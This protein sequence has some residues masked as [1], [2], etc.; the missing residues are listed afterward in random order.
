MRDRRTTP[1]FLADG[2]EMGALMRAHDWSASTLGP[3]EG[4]PQPLRTVVRLLLNTRH[5]T[6]IFWGA[7]GACLY[8]D[9]YRQS[10]GFERHPSSL[11]RPA[12][13]VWN[14]IWDIIGPQIDYVMAGQGATWHEDQL[15]P[16]TRNGE[17]EDVY[18]TYSYG[19]IDDETAANGVGG[20]LVL[21]TETTT[22]VQAKQRLAAEVARQRQVFERAP[23]FIAVLHGPEHR[24]EFV[25]QAY[26][27]LFGGRNFIARTVREAFPELEGQGLLEVLDQVYATGERFVA[28]E[29][30]IRLRSTPAS[31]PTERFFDF[32]Y[33]PM[34]DEAGCIT[35]IFVEGYDVSERMTAEAALRE[36]NEQL[37]QRVEERT[38]ERDRLWQNSQDILAVIDIQGRFHAVS[39]VVTKVLGWTPDELV[40]RSALD[41]VHPEHRPSTELALA[42]AAHSELPAHDNLYRHK[43]GSYRWISWVSAPGGELIYATGRHVTGEKEAAIALERSQARLRTVFETSYQMQGLLAL[44]GTVLDANATSLAVIDSTLADVVGRAFWETPWFT[45]TPGMPEKVRAAVLAAADGEN[46]REEISVNVAVGLRSYDFSVRPI[47]DRH[48]TVIAIVPEAADTTEHRQAEEALR[49]SQK[50]E[51]VG[52]LTGG[53]A[54]DFN[55]LLT[56][57]TGSLE[58]L[59]VRMAQGRV[60]EFNRYITAAQGASK[61]AAALTHR[62][63]AFSRRQP[64]DPKAVDVNQLVGGMEELVRRTVGP[65][66]R[67]EVTGAAGLWT[68][69]ADPNQLES[70][71]LNLCINARDAMPDGGRLM[72]ETDNCRLDDNAGRR[73]ELPPGQYVALSVSDTGT[74]MTPDV[75]A[76]AFDPFFTTKPIG[77]GTGLGLSMIYG[78]ARQSGG[79][80][81]ISS[82]PGRG[83]TVRLYLPRHVGHADADDAPAKLAAAPRA[84]RGQ[85]VLVVDDEPTVRML[86]SEVLEDLGYIVVEAADGEAGLRVLHSDAR[87][88]LL[89]TDLGLPGGTNGRQVADAGRML[90]PGL[91]VLFITGYT[92]SA[93]IGGGPL[94]S[95]MHV[96]IKPFAMEAL[97]SRIKALIAGTP[98]Y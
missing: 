31:A 4:W 82:R 28:Y 14:E 52:Q 10:V 70:A 51:A 18:W 93:A 13:E 81:R 67:V 24:F 71:L 86:V 73:R 32:V 44:D 19:P 80:V 59:Q 84:G 21:C 94:E 17:R 65:A 40:G 56:G 55:N 30:G 72:I 3:P 89:I 15:V 22:N 6:Y 46:F 76:R 63:L 62:L 88:D 35:G 53:I 69:L 61:R 2:G 50:M 27:R 37:E 34:R 54:H 43:D 97:A 23:G 90:R 77:Q 41:I 16:I 92:D 91:R 38:R 8:N 11:G 45:A 60:G 79:Q 36:L 20:V 68:T 9:A 7:A 39:P 42:R 29:H 96:L 57:I 49:Q 87:I 33:E 47:R 1:G 74:G 78:F 48:G 5:P 25:N 64:L 26:S 58:L 85:T 66:V 75:A 95:G 12:R 98:G 83:T